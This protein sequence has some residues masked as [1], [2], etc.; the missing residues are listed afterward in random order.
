[1][2]SSATYRKVGG[3]C[4]RS[5]ATVHFRQ[6][7]L[8]Q[9]VPLRVCEDLGSSPTRSGLAH[10]SSEFS[11]SNSEL[12][13]EIGAKLT[14]SALAA[15]M[16]FAVHLRSKLNLDRSFSLSCGG[17]SCS[18]VTQ[19]ADVAVPETL[20]S[21]QFRM[22]Q[23]SS[24]RELTYYRGLDIVVRLVNEFIHACLPLPS[25]SLER[26]SGSPRWNISH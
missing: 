9:P 17:S 23:I 20:D 7:Y 6:L 10:R 18:R 22:S 13:T 21:T 16:E 4:L 3:F 24:V 25:V 26:R 8:S 1:M 12:Y 15:Y 14:V 5:R 2:R 19:K 11:C